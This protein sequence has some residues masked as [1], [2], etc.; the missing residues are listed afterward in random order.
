MVLNDDGSLDSAFVNNINNLSTVNH[1][2]L[3][4]GLATIG[5]YFDSPSS[6]V[7][8][9]Y[10]QR[11]FVLVVSPGMSSEDLA[12]AAGSE[13]P[14]FSDYDDDGLDSSDP[15]TLIIDDVSVIIPQNVNGST[16]LDDVAHYMATN[17]MVGY[18]P[19]A[20][21]VNTYT[22]GFMGSEGNKR[23]LINTS[24]NGNDN[25]NLYDSSDPE[26][27]KYHFE[28]AS[29][30][31]LAQSIID[32][33]TA[34]LENSNTFAA[35]VVPITRTTSGNRIYLSFF[36]PSGTSNFWEGNVVKFGLG[37][38][39]Q[40]EDKNGLSA[41]YANGALKEDAEAYWQTVDWADS[42]KD[43]Y[44]DNTG[45]NIYTYLGTDEVIGADGNAFN[46]TNIT[47]AMLALPTD[48]IDPTAPEDPV[49]MEEIINYVRGADVFDEDGDEVV[50]ENRKLITG[51]VLHSEP[52][53]YQYLHSTGTIPVN[54]VVADPSVSAAGKIVWGTEGGSATV[55]S[56]SS[57]ELVYENLQMPFAEGELLFVS[58]SST[59]AKVDQD[60]E[61]VD[62]ALYPTMVFYGANDGML[63]AVRDVDGIE[64]WGF[65]PPNQLARL[66]L[67]VE[68]TGHQYYVDSS[69][70]MYLHD[71]YGNGFI[72]IADG[73]KVILVSGERK[74]SS[75]YFALDVTDPEVPKF[76][77]R[78]NSGTDLSP[79]TA[80]YTITQ[81]GES[82]SEPHFGKVKTSDTDADTGT[83][84]MIIGGG[85]SDTNAGSA[86][87]II[88][89]LTGEP[90]KIFDGT[91][92][93][94]MDYSIPSEVRVLDTDRNGFIDKLYVGDTGGQLWRI[95]SFEETFH[96][97]DE[98]IA[99]WQAQMIF[100]AGCNESDCTDNF[101]NNNNGL[102][103]E[104]RTFYYPPTVVLRENYDLVFIG[105]GDR[106]NPCHWDTQDEMYS[107]Q[108]D[109]SLLPPDTAWTR[110]DL[111]DITDPT[112]ALDPTKKGWLLRL[113]SGEKVLSSGTV[114]A[115]TLYFTTFTPNDDP[116]LPGGLA[117]LY[118]VDYR[119]GSAVLNLDKDTEEVLE[120]SIVIGG[121][122]PSK[123]VIV[124]SDGGQEM[125]ISVGSVNPDENSP[126][127]GAGIVQPDVL[128]EGGNLNIIR[129][130]EVH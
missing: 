57:T 109:H 41:T 18:Q 1:S 10:C 70:K 22:V 91:N 61:V 63:H 34:I 5:G 46:S 106:E 103:N 75:G 71:V 69:P 23:F 85:Y 77:W 93:A 40:I 123:T 16:W 97:A 94:G 55:T 86:I 6:G 124:I 27:G 116:C 120:R 104:L 58:G 73:D 119:D 35:P 11:N 87:L 37:S 45:R 14:S 3:A 21:Y 111:T 114:F 28:A 15:V 79:D 7:V 51:S 115:G 102:I 72:D 84:V 54:S 19:G 52:L 26:Y 81:L 62:V 90:I 107:I 49:Y 92:S 36:T 74:G 32:A 112:V 108:D 130:R 53:V 48:P 117:S 89:V 9:S 60:S 17:D 59:T 110:N 50:T 101:D 76:L 31:L 68:G 4:E 43:N 99:G 88:D 96:A 67:L 29:P 25:T 121:G 56:L 66:K 30:E 82:W 125:L 44:M 127:L 80:A 78:I 20:Q 128:P 47:A 113:N 13:P 8:D 118:A 83:P 65:I 12:P 64:A 95:G 126:S 2:P 129:W 39:L 100:T 42:T 105:S 122:I 98:N 33:L 24:N 38:A